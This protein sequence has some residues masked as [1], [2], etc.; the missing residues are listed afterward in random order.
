M[1]NICTIAVIILGWFQTVSSAVSKQ[2]LFVFRHCV[3]IWAKLHSGLPVLNE[4]IHRNI[5]QKHFWRVLLGIKQLYSKG[6]NHKLLLLIF[7]KVTLVYLP[8]V[9]T[10]L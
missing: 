9:C 4:I 10:V 2:A 5:I 3:L 7:Y 1:I 6:R 8:V